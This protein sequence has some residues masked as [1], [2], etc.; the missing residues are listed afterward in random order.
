MTTVKVFLNFGNRKNFLFYG[1][2]NFLSDKWMQTK[3][4]LPGWIRNRGGGL[5]KTSDCFS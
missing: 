3:T 4:R 1:E 2:S 5:L